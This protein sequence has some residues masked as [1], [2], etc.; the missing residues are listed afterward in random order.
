VLELGGTELPNIYIFIYLTYIL[1]LYA[2][3]WIQKDKR[4]ADEV[5]CPKRQNDEE[6]HSYYVELWNIL[7]I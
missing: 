5:N 6:S 4:C 7:K 2:I 3:S 1:E